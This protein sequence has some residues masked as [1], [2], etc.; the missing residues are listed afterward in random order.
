L[1]SSPH[2]HFYDHPLLPLLFESRVGMIISGTPFIIQ[3]EKEK[4]S[5]G[6]LI[7]CLQIYE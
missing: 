6:N 3:L 5:G 1:E 7:E 2:F 4:K